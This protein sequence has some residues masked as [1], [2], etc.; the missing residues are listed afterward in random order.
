MGNRSDREEIRVLTIRNLALRDEIAQLDRRLYDLERWKDRMR[1]RDN[2]IIERLNQKQR[3]RER[4]SDDRNGRLDEITTNIEE[5]SRRFGEALRI[6][7]E[8][9]DREQREIREINERMVRKNRE[10]VERI[11]GRDERGFSTF[12]EGELQ[13]CEICLEDLITNYYQCNLCHNNWCLDCQSRLHHCPYC[14]N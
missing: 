12:V 6:L 2:V 5:R 7:N 8:S 4:E 1:E 14:R 3:E 13:Q 10:H 11:N 9:I